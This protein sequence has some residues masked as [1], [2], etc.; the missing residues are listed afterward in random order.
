MARVKV[1]PTCGYQNKSKALLCTN[2]E[3]KCNARLMNVVPTK[4][5]PVEESAVGNVMASKTVTSTE[6]NLEIEDVIENP[7]STSDC[8]HVLR[9]G[10]D[11]CVYCLDVVGA[12]STKPT[13]GAIT[14]RMGIRLSH[15]E[16]FIE[17]ADRVLVGR[18]QSISP[19]AEHIPL[20]FD[21]ISRRHAELWVEGGKAY[22]KDAGSTNGTF[23][24]GDKLAAEVE[25]PVKAGDEIRFAADY[26]VI[27]EVCHG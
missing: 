14:P 20:S 27:W 18:D 12:G 26:T 21:N 22:V 17:I 3:P 10:S 16:Q 8:Q 1:C 7:S 13:E 19:I 2:T 11:Q 9:E 4:P 5:K 6:P 23:I 25:Q 15:N 24:N